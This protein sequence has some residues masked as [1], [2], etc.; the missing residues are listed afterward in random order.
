[1][2][3]IRILQER[4]REREFSPF[5]CKGFGHDIKKQ[6]RKDFDLDFVNLREWF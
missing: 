3:W 4:E 1:M 2:E 6:T 5:P